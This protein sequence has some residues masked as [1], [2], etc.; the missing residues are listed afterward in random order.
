MKKRKKISWS[1]KMKKFNNTSG[2]TWQ[3]GCSS[4]ILALQ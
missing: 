2:D 4:K 3:C 1:I